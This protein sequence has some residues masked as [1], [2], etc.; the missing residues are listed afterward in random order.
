MGLKVL[1]NA[2]MRRDREIVHYKSL[3]TAGGALGPVCDLV[4]NAMSDPDA[5]LS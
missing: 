4:L 3:K 1:A 2:P 5:R